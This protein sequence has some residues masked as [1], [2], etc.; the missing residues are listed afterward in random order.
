MDVV[1]YDLTPPL[2]YPSLPSILQHSNTPVFQH[3]KT[4]DLRPKTYFSK[5]LF[6]S[7]IDFMQGFLTKSGLHAPAGGRFSWTGLTAMLLSVPLVGL[8]FAR[9]GAMI[10]CYFPP[11]G[12]IFLLVGVLIGLTI[13]ALTRIGQWGHRP[14]ILSAA[15]AAALVAASVPGGAGEMPAPP[16]PV[17]PEAGETPAPQTVSPAPQTVSHPP[18]RSSI[19]SLRCWPSPERWPQLYPPCAVPYCDRCGSWFRTVRNGKIDLPASQRLA[20]LLDVEVPEGGRSPRFR[21]SACRGECGPTRCELSWERTGGGV[22]LARVW[23]DAEQ[24]NEVVAI[25]DELNVEESET[26]GG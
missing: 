5:R 21:L 14:T 25:I 24:R 2:R 23:L 22:D 10:Q 12:L 3:S 7:S 17:S 9:I 1:M 18:D 15:V 26:D 13:V 4:Q 19:R 16:V 8:A 6:H 11:S 20:E